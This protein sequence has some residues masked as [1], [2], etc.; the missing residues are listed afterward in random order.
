LSIWEDSFFFFNFF[1]DLGRFFF[2]LQFFL[3]IW[4]D[5]FFSFF[6]SIFFLRKDGELKDIMIKLKRHDVAENEVRK[7]ADEMDKLKDCSDELLDRYPGPDGDNVEKKVE[8]VLKSWDALKRTVLKRRTD[9][10]GLAAGHVWLNSARALQKWGEDTLAGMSASQQKDK[11]SVDVLIQDHNDVKADISAH[12]PDFERL[13]ADSGAVGGAANPLSGQVKERKKDLK[14][15]Q[16]KLQQLWEGRRASLEEESHVRKF[17]RDLD[18]LDVSSNAQV[19]SLFLTCFP[20]IISKIFHRL[21]FFQ[22]LIK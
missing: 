3:S 9:L 10:E 21:S 4:E 18:Q 13:L 1:V 15:L 12:K 11:I 5:S 6:S 17:L 8:N 16:D 22:Y 2:F 7:I 19:F 14:V 20:F